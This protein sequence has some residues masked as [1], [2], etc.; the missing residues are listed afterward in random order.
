MNCY[1]CRSYLTSRGLC[2]V[3]IV[4]I[5]GAKHE[6]CNECWDKHIHWQDCDDWECMEQP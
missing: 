1:S 5:K 2:K 3:Y 6:I 4:K